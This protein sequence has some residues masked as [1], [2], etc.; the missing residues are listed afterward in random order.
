MEMKF[1]CGRAVK[2]ITPRAGI[3]L[4]GFS[5][6]SGPSR[7]VHDRLFAKAVVVSDSK[8]ELAIVTTDLLGLD[9]DIVGTIREGAEEELGIAAEMIMLCCSHTHS[10]P[11]TITLR[12][13][14][15]RDRNYVEGLES[16]ILGA[17]REAKVNWVE[18]ILKVGEGS[19]EIGVNRR[20]RTAEGRIMLG[21]NAFGTTDPNVAVIGIEAPGLRTV[22]F[23]YA[24]HPVVLGSSNLLISAD[25]PGYAVRAIQSAFG[26]GVA[27]FMQ[28]CC[29]NIN[30][31]VVGGTF[32]DAEEIGGI[33]GAEAIRVANESSAD[34]E[35]IGIGGCTREIE[36]ALSDVPGEDAIEDE[37]SV[38][39][40]N[41]ASAR[42]DNDW[43]AMKHAQGLMGWAEDAAAL[44][45]VGG[46]IS[47][48]GWRYRS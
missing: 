3:E 5:G 40:A 33:L 17:I 12:G 22:L 42:R 13:L 2:D 8:C 36:L 10:G 45:R 11:A 48:S 1:K 6:R 46:D 38:Y 47:G 21:Q 14:G 20:E 34:E 31:K 9:G 28:G 37:L 4:T 39:R 7:G 24:C 16:V 27:M 29:G 19:C 32:G 44:A 18:S 43:G 15:D 25:F 41:Y 26:N 30:P 35:M 23:N